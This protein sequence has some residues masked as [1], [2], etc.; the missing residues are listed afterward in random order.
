MNREEELWSGKFGDAYHQRNRN[1]D[2]LASNIA[3]FARVL[4]STGSLRSIIEF[5]AGTGSNLAAIETLLPHAQIAG[6]ELH[7]DAAD[8]CR[9]GVRTIYQQ[10]IL[11]WEPDRTWD[12][13]MSKG[14]LIHLEPDT[15]PQVYD[16]LYAASNQ[17]IMIAEYYAPQPYSISYRGVENAIHKRDFA[18]EM[19][20]RHPDLKLVSYDFVSKYDRWPQDDLTWFLMEKQ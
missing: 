8:C 7:P 17:Y 12:M 1:E 11:E 5:G 9:K 14:V 18:G 3:F 6:I 19:M 4:R 15:L 2:T 13:A 10:S 16:K 20:R